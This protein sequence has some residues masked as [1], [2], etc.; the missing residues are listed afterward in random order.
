MHY[1]NWN[2]GM[3][4]GFGWWIFMTIMMIVFWGGLI[5]FAATVIR[6]PDN[7]SHMTG[8]GMG[9]PPT[10]SNVARKTAQEILDTRLARGEIELDDYR[11]R[12]EALRSPKE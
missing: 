11:L 4:G 9:T 7:T 2:D 8:P 5:W 6:R 12:L 3:G 10:T 1:G